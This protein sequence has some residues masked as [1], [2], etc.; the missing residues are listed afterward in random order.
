MATRMFKNA[1]GVELC[2][3]EVIEIAVHNVLCCVEAKD[4]SQY[5]VDTLNDTDLVEWAT[6][7]EGNWRKY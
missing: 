7:D 3:D 1:A 2:E 6:D 5:Y 4:L